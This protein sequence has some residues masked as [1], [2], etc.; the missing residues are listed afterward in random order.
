MQQLTA[1]QLRAKHNR[2]RMIKAR[3]RR[4]FIINIVLS[5]I[6]KTVLTF[7]TIQG[8][9]RLDANPERRAEINKFKLYR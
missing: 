1:N 9:R 6:T 4:N 7:A 2:N 8:E 3:K 5:A